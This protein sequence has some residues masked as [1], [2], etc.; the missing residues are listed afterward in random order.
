LEFILLY[1][2]IKIEIEEMLLT[3][4]A[5]YTKMNQLFGEMLNQ[6]L[7]YPT[8]FGRRFSSNELMMFLDNFFQY[9]NC[10][11]YGG[12]GGE[13]SIVLGWSY[14]SE[15][16]YKILRNRDIKRTNYTY[17]HLSDY[18]ELPYWYYEL[19]LLIPAITHEVVS[20][21]IKKKKLEKEFRYRRA[22]EKF[23]K[24]LLHFFEDRSNN[25]VREIGDIL[26]YEWIV[27]ELSIEIF[28][29]IVAYKIHGKSYVYTL[30]HN[31]LAEGVARDFLEVIYKR[32][33]NGGKVTHT[34]EGYSFRPNDWF[35]SAK[36]EYSLLRL[37]IL[38]AIGERDGVCE[39]DEE[40]KE[41]FQE[42]KKIV[43][44]IMPLEE[45]KG[46]GGF[47]E[48]FRYDYPNYYPT[49]S[50]VKNFLS[51][52]YEHILESKIEKS[53]P[54]KHLDD[55]PGAYRGVGKEEEIVIPKVVTDMFNI[56]WKD[57]FRVLKDEGSSQKVP[58]KGLF[59]KLIHE[60]ISGIEFPEEGEG[61]VD[62]LWYLRFC[63]FGGEGEYYRSPAGV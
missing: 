39:R 15:F 7:P 30:F 19:P 44:L 6:Y 25:L 13:N 56:L 63:L 9:L 33:E 23:R 48:I 53:I 20:L 24:E 17:T 40:G 10:E 54:I 12:E 52:L 29:D 26:G 2:Y 28:S 11:I 62:S 5:L 16:R 27:D 8:F 51:Q 35:F 47:D 37:H 41:Y 58:Y 45:G 32:E 42:M 34:V 46:R 50:A 18:I 43:N 14:N 1:D 21:P 3:I 57:R 38:L 36:R 55:F 61:E 49:Y 59:R 60:K 31:L 4:E 22:Y